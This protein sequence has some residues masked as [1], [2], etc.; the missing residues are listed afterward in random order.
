MLKSV[1]ANWKQPVAYHFVK[2]ASIPAE[3]VKTV[4]QIVRETHKSGFKV[5]ALVCDQG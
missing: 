5:V 3:I 1:A 2:D 4:R